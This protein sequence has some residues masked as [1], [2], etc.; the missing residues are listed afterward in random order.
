MIPLGFHRVEAEVLA[1]AEELAQAQGRSKVTLWDLDLAQVQVEDFAYQSAQVQELQLT[2]GQESQSAPAPVSV[3]ESAL[4]KGY[5]L[6]SEMGL[7]RDFESAQV[8]ELELG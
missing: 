3:Q 4:P 8:T 2:Q 1:K 5:R 7:V 6:D